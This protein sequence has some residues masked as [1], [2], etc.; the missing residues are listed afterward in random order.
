[1]FSCLALPRE[2]FSPNTCPAAGSWCRWRGFC[3]PDEVLGSLVYD[4]VDVRLPE[5]LLEGGRRLLEYG[6]NEG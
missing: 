6:S 2:A 3:A 5:Q 1:M 4:D